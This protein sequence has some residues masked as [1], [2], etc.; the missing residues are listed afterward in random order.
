MNWETIFN[1][2]ATNDYAVAEHF[3][4]E[5]LY[6][7]LNKYLLELST[8]NKLEKSGIGNKHKFQVNENIRGD[9]IFW[10][11]PSNTNPTLLSFFQL[12]QELQ[13]ELNRNFYL[14]LSDFEFHFAHYPN[15]SFYTKHLDQFKGN[16][17]RLI[18]VIFYFNN[19][20]KPGDGGELKIYLENEEKLIEPIANRM[21]I[22]RS[23]KIEHEVLTTF[24]DRYSLTGWMLYKPIGL[25]FL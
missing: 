20:W 1:S 18:T 21:I 25:N 22:F 7:S 13:A 23:G 17:N 3:F 12:M 11:D 10:L 4:S 16:N 14:S 15:G 5:N 2:L 8:A 24:V 6:N 19:Q 9:Q